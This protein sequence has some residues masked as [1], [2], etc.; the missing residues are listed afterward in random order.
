MHHIFLVKSG[1]ALSCQCTLPGEQHIPPRKSRSRSACY[2]FKYRSSRELAC[3]ETV[4]GYAAYAVPWYHCFNAG[5]LLLLRVHHSVSP[6]ALNVTVLYGWWGQRRVVARVCSKIGAVIHLPLMFRLPFRILQH[7][8]TATCFPAGPLPEL[9]RPS[10]RQVQTLLSFAVAHAL[11]S[12]P[13]Q[14]EKQKPGPRAQWERQPHPHKDRLS[15]FSRASDQP[16]RAHCGQLTRGKTGHELE[17]P[18]GT[19]EQVSKALRGRRPFPGCLTQSSEPRKEAGSRGPGQGPHLQSRP[20]GSG[21]FTEGVSVEQKRNKHLSEAT[22]LFA[23][24]YSNV[25]LL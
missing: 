23:L 17:G 18:A 14:R 7:K 9:F 25:A 15:L 16:G 2:C 10:S 19:A 21:P 13:A 3:P 20:K 12:A 8:C 5:T 1:E 24:W 4:Q 11:P 6:R 22:L